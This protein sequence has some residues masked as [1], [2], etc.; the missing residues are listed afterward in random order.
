MNGEKIA[1]TMGL[2]MEFVWIP[3]HRGV[4]GNELADKYA[5]AVTR[6]VSVDIRIPYSNRNQERD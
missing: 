1:A 5:K 3:A 4:E 6:R 2:S